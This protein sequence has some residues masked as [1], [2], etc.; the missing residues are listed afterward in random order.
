MINAFLKIRCFV[1][2]VIENLKMKLIHY[3]QK[4][5]LKSFKKMD[6]TQ[7]VK[8]IKEIL[9]TSFCN[10]SILVNSFQ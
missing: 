6:L 4:E 2:N 1:L 8:I 3:F 10:K 9:W 7:K 5:N